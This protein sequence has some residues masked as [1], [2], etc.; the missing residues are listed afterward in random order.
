[1]GRVYKGIHPGIRSRVAIKVLSHEH[2]ARP[3][4]IERFFAEARAVN[5]IRHE[6][7]VNVLDLSW[8]PDGRPCIVMEYLDGMPLSHAIAARGRLPVG[9]LARVMGE[10]LGALGAAHQKGV[11]HRDVKPDNIFVSLEGRAKVLDFGI[12]KLAAEH[13]P[14]AGS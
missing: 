5:L 3:E 8:L 11:V 1:M 4:L 9:T 13:L 14:P 10:V 2:A 12:A 6:S 7:I